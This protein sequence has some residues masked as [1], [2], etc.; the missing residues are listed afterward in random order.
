MT[1]YT[2]PQME[3]EVIERATQECSH[4][5][6][7]NPNVYNKLVETMNDAKMQSTFK[8]LKHISNK[9]V[10]EFADKLRDM[11]DYCKEQYE[12]ARNNKQHR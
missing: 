11:V 4:E 1:L 9:E 12:E 3:T 7:N 6:M 5:L 2:D 10:S 8:N